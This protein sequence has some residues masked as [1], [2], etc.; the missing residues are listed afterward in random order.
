MRQGPAAS[1]RSSCSP[2]RRRRSAAATCW[3]I[4]AA[5]E[6]H[7]LPLGI[8]AGSSYRHSITSLGWPSYYIED[9]A[10]H[11]A[12]VSVAGGEPGRA[13]G[14]FAKYP[15]LKVVLARIGRDLA[16]R[17]PLAVL[18]VL[19]RRALG[20][21]VGRP[22]AGRDRARPCP[23]DHPAVRRAG[24]PRSGGTGDRSSAFRCHTALSPRTIRTGSS[25]ATRRHAGG[26][27][28]RAC[29]AKSWWRIRLRPMIASRAVS[30]RACRVR[31]IPRTRGYRRL[32]RA[33]AGHATL[34]KEQPP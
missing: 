10:S 28:R 6:R 15:G 21:A 1:C 26:H 3:P 33:F 16:S 19:A 27:T 23:P 32:A 8:H 34:L 30:P 22:L 14:V 25:T 9:Y 31:T 11:S 18:E 13:K 4:Y 7:G 20:G 17:L 2:C 5:A 24:R 29:I 12:G